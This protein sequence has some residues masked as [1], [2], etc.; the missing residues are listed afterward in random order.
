MT[1]NAKAKFLPD[2]SRCS[3]WTANWIS[4]KLIF[5]WRW[6]RK[7]PCDAGHLRLKEW[8][9]LEV[10]IRNEL[11]NE[12]PGFRQ[13]WTRKQVWM[14]RDGKI[15]ISPP[16]QVCWCDT[17]FRGWASTEEVAPQ[18]LR[19]YPRTTGVYGEGQPEV[20]RLGAVNHVHIAL[21]FWRV[22]NTCKK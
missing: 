14:G 9:K 4:W 11:Q 16:Q 19:A 2:L 5:K 22:K 15:K 20:L 13:Q 12:C 17:H 3:M 6:K 1:A 18:T 8:S 10:M 21:P 7:K